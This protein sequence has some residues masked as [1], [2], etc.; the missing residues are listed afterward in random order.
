MAEK[1][2]FKAPALVSG[3]TKLK[4][5]DI[6][7]V[8]A[9]L[10]IPVIHFCIFWIYINANSLMMAFQLPSGKWSLDSFRMVFMNI[11][12]GEK[13]SDSLVVSIRNTLLFFVTNI[14][15][16]PFHILI[17]YFLFRRIKGFRT[18]QIIFYLPAI[19]SGVAITEMFRQFIAPDGP[20]GVVLT[21]LGVK[22][23]P[24]FLANSKYSI[25][26]IWFYTI[27]LGWGGNMML[28]GGTL[29]RVPMEILESARVDGI[30]TPKE[31]VYMICP[32]IWPTVSTLLILQMTTIFSASGPIL[33]FTGGDF[34]T[35]TIGF[36][37][38]SKIK[39]GG[40]AMYNQVAAAGLLFT[41]IG[42]PI[43]LGARWL[44]EKIPVVDY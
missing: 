20:L 29:A 7:F 3:K 12:A 11:K 37:I 10:A 5:W 16:I 2:Q 33:L 43:I 21:N 9:M 44:I 40:N 8:I 4:K 22:E 34:K 27:W 13:A 42:M 39:Y 25:W 38:F 41:A 24:H 31:I 15:M 17:S 36:W 28:L 26:T 6:I 35:S 1:R 14:G 30:N 19:V 18:F 23:I 32:L